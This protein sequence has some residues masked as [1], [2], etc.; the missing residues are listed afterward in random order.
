[1]ENNNTLFEKIG[2]MDAVK[3]AVDIF[4]EKL[5]K[6]KSISHFFKGVDLKTQKAKQAAFLAYAF[7]GPVKY[8]GKDMRNAHAKLV[9]KG[10]NEDHFNSVAGHLVDTLKELG[11]KKDLV[12]QV[13]E[14]ALSVKNDVLGIDNKSNNEEM[15]L[16]KNIKKGN[17][18]PDSENSNLFRSLLVEAADA[19]VTI[20]E[21]KNVI[22]W[23]KAAEKLWGYTEDETIGKNIKNFVP[24]EHKSQHDQYIES[25]IKTGVDKIVGT[26]REVEV[27]RK[28]GSR[29]PI[30]L[31]MTKYKEGEKTYYMAIC[32]DISEQKR[33]LEEAQQATEE[34]AAQEEELRQNMEELQATQEAIEQEKQIMQDTLEQ[35][36]DAIITIDENKLVRFYNAAAERIFG[37]TREEV[38]GQNVKMI[39]PVEHRAPHDSYVD[40]NM[41]TGVNKVVGHERRLEATRKNGERFWITLSLSKVE[42]DGNFQYTAFIKDVTAQVK[43]EQEIEAKQRQ[44]DAQ[45]EIL[46]ASCLVSE[47]D[48][49]GVITYANDKFCEV[50]KYDREELIGQPHNI[51]RHPDMPKEVF[52]EM[53]ATIGKGKLFNGVVKNK[54]KDGTPYYVDA[55]IAPV[56]GQ[57]G[58]PE[59]YIGVRYDITEAVATQEAVKQEAEKMNSTLDQA[60]DAVI[61]MDGKTKEILFFNKAA[62][63]MWGYTSEEVIGKNIK[64]IVPIEHRAAHDSYVDANIKTGVNK[65]VGTTREV[66]VER[67]DGSRF[68]A[69]LGISK[70]EF[71]D[72]ILYTAFVKDISAQKN[73]LKEVN[74]V[75][76]FAAEEG[77]LGERIN[78]EGLQ[79]D[80]LALSDSMNS[81]LGS[82]ADPL[83]EIKRLIAELAKGNL[84][85]D[86]NLSVEGDLKELGDAYNNA[87]GNLNNLLMNI[88]EVANLV[89]ASSEELL[90]KSDQMQA[91]TQEVASAI[92]QMAEGAHQQA[93][94]TDEASKLV[95]EV[96]HSANDTATKADMIN[97]AADNGQKSS[98]EGLTTVQ[99]VVENMEEIQSSAN[100]TSESIEVLNERSEEIART[101]NVITD[102][103]AQTNLLALNAAIE[104]ARAGD[105]GRG[106]AVVAEEI[107]KLAE[108]SR[109]S[110]VDIQ[111]VV[112]AVQKDIT[113]ASKAIDAMGVSVKSGNAASKE[114]EVVFGSIGKMTGETFELS[115]EIQ[116]A[117]E[118]QKSSINETVKN[119]EKIV[120]VSEETAAGTE[121][122][123]TSSKDLS[124]GMDEVND[125]SKQLATAANQLNQGVSKFK[126]KY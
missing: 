118:E 8:T 66:E 54:A 32:K 65:I 63:K 42:R 72:E 120:V 47:T 88:S 71:G 87:V 22:F 121:Q 115:Q 117:T 123:A 126:L 122:I 19:V 106:F 4:Y 41:Q 89:A 62:E 85:E 124:Q 80:W 17:E 74:R 114:A 40:A 95:E 34:I 75:V 103:A 9:E 51:V 3:A 113:Q 57:N 59:K 20:D 2:G 26:G 64:E 13:V 92:Q 15:A 79:G 102:I 29:V 109:K 36:L 100:M 69:D 50:A 81:L 7:G 23:N 98:K 30:L 99:K 46:N 105:A 96:L 119:I 58:K 43:Q 44:I 48:L 112:T 55:Y 77:N 90:T 53:W 27:Q 91:T 94:Q 60:V 16:G 110:A 116:R 49:K 5:L 12:E 33:I 24:D 1:M 76:Q 107:R 21:T 56:M 93:S 28:D 35:A 37:F 83:L 86:F 108:D 25:N 39:V 61:A 111:K 125:T 68:W 101:L 78:T 31:T 10:L 73:I 18:S 97:K 6:D 52:K 67:K 82:V 11:I 14:I 45:L 38:I 84:S 104:A 70:V